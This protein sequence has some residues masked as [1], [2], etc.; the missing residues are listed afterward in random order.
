MGGGGVELNPLTQHN[1]CLSRKL[2]DN[3]RNNPCINITSFRQHI[4]KTLPLRS[5]PRYRGYGSLEC[6]TGRQLSASQA[7]C[8]FFLV[9]LMLWWSEDS[10][11]AI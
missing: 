5:A 1:E 9:Q 10:R 8:Y 6:D 11:T 4:G 7:C 3:L 2:P